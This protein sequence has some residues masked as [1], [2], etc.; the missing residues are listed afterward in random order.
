MNALYIIDIEQNDLSG[1]FTYLSYEQ[2]IQ[3]IATFITE[4]KLAVWNFWIHNT[5][6]LGCLPRELATT[7]A[8]NATT[9]YD[10]Y[11]RLVPLNDAAQEF[12]RQLRAL[13][14]EL[15]SEMTNANILYVHIFSVK[16]DLIANAAKY[17]TTLPRALV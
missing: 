9:D 1:S 8:Q 4:I 11:G 16:Y 17:S 15:R 14:E 12:N 10:P 5:G 7:S 2:V 6:P 13:C 3:N